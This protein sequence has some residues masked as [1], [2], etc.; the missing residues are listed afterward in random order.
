[1][2]DENSPEPKRCSE[3]FLSS[4]PQDGKCHVRLTFFGID[5][6]THNL[7]GGTKGENEVKPFKADLSIDNMNS[8]VEFAKCSLLP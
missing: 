3:R 5:G 4:Q 2:D 1:M 7:F 8:C 6:I